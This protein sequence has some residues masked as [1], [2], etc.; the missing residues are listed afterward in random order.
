MLC[1]SIALHFKYPI[2]YVLPFFE[3]SAVEEKYVYYFYNSVIHTFSYLTNRK[4]KSNMTQK[5]KFNSQEMP[6]V[7]CYLDLKTTTTKKNP[8]SSLIGFEWLLD[9]D[10]SQF[11]ELMNHFL[12]SGIL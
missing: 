6:C 8:E 1:H 9:E 11:C 10:Q 3:N 12:T 7:S 5:T 4:L 2:V